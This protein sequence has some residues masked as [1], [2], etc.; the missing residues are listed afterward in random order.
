MK[1]KADTLPV[2]VG[3]V[4]TLMMLTVGTLVIWTHVTFSSALGRLIYSGLTQP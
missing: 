1:T 4:C 2:I 3:A